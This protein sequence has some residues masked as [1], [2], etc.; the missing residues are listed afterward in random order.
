MCRGI[1]QSAGRAL[2]ERRGDPRARLRSEAERV[3]ACLP[4]LRIANPK[5]VGEDMLHRLGMALAFRKR[6]CIESGVRPRGEAR[7]T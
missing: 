5:R 4:I 3:Q 1:V 7:Q 2:L 6:L